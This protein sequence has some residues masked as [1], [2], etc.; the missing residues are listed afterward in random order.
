[1]ADQPTEQSREEAKATYL[2]VAQLLWAKATLEEVSGKPEATKTKEELELTFKQVSSMTKSEVGMLLLNEKYSAAQDN[3]ITEEEVLDKVANFTSFTRGEIPDAAKL[4]ELKKD[5][6]LQAQ[7][8]E[9]F[10]KL[11]KEFPDNNSTD[12]KID[13]NQVA[14]KELEFLAKAFPEQ[15]KAVNAE[16]S[17][18]GSVGLTPIETLNRVVETAEKAFHK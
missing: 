11:Q 13:V 10:A 2:S 8:K 18:S 6:K 9:E 3:I 12:G 7:A 14:A 15:M 5:P 17:K 1:M 4:A 16:I